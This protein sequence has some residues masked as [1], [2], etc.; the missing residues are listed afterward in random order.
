[1]VCSC[2]PNFHLATALTPEG[3][4]T[5]TNS[6][7]VGNFDPF[8]LR[9]KVNPNSIITGAPVSY[10]VTIN[11]EDV[12]IKSIWGTP[13]PT[14][15]L[16]WR[17]TYVGRYIAPAEGD[18]YVVLTNAPTCPTDVLLTPFTPATATVNKTDNTTAS[19]TATTASAKSATKA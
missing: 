19:T 8:Y 18:P 3:V 11:G 16:W 14:D 7:N 5:V 1:M 15:R 4:L 6:T 17:V 2:N 10:G 13:I 12:A 9:L